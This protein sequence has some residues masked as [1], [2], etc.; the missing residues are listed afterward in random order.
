MTR[1]GAAEDNVPTRA[2][3]SVAEAIP[4]IPVERLQDRRIHSI[5]LR[6]GR[7]GDSPEASTSDIQGTTRFSVSLDTTDDVISDAWRRVSAA[8]E[9][10]LEI[11][12]CGSEAHR[13]AR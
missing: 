5:C 3:L 4:P 6:L 8:I 9:K 12:T 11:S 10:L 2:A 13:V 1:E 7:P